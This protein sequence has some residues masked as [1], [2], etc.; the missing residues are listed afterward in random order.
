MTTSSAAPA[1]LRPLTRRR[2]LGCGAAALTGATL[3]A[4]GGCSPA[5]GTDRALVYGSLD[6]ALRE[7]DRLAALDDLHPATDWSLSQTLAHCA[8][9]I[10][11]SLQGFPVAKSELFQQT[12]GRAAFSV[13]A[14]RGRMHHDLAEPIPGAQALAP[15]LD[16]HQA[17]ARL[18]TAANAFATATGPLQPHFAYGALTRAQYEQA[19]AMHLANHF[20]AMDA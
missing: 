14:W 10:E 9:S 8:Q 1:Q 15:T 18:H 17:L 6:E 3:P 7:A 2:L 5:S 20:S 12:L 4:L 11:Y 13:F 16:K 19:H